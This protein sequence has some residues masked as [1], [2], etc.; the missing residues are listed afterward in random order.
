MSTKTTDKYANRKY[1]IEAYDPAWK[2]RFDAEAGQLR[3]VFGESLRAIEHVGSTS[4]PGLAGKPTIDILVT[5]NSIHEA[6][7]LSRQIE[8]LGYTALGDYINQGS[9]LFAKER[10]NTRFVNLH[11]FEA[12][13]PKVAAML[14]LRDYFRNHPAV[15]AE[16]SQLKLDLFHRYP[17]DYA[18]Y[19]KYKDEWME[20]IKKQIE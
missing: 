4:V 2:E 13:S 5:M 16:Y 12:A 1:N 11:V 8:A 14:K 17:N 6:D 3:P 9:R 7:A 20:E 15:V 10:D 19:R 18:S